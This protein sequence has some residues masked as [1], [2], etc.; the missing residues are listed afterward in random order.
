MSIYQIMRE[1]DENALSKSRRALFGEEFPEIYE[2]FRNRFLFLEGGTDETLLLENYVLLGNFIHDPD[3]FEVFEEL[4]LDFVR[5]FVHA[6][7]NA[8]ELS[9]SRKSYERLME[10]AR[11]LRSRK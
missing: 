1:L 5:D 9:R 2:L 4:L 8:E 10:Q 11:S 6:D 3:R 7:E